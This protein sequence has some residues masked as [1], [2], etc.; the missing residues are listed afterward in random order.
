M[1][2]FKPENLNQLLKV[3]LISANKSYD[4]IKDYEFTGEAV[5]FRVDFDHIDVSL[6]IVDMLGRSASKFNILPFAKLD[7]NEI[8]YIQFQVYSINEGNFKELIDTM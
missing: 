6:M 5:V 3:M 2:N 1:I 7:T 4:A 8:D